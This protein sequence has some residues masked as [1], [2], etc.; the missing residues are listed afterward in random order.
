M[1]N[2]TFISNE[3]AKQFIR[4]K[5]K[6]YELNKIILDINYLVYTNN[7]EPLDYKTKSTLFTHIFDVVAGRKELQ[8]KEEEKNDLIPDFKDI[9]LLFERRNF[10][11]KQLKA[12]IKKQRQLS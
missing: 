3:M 12:G 8:L 6:N 1:S 9:T 5:D 11:L 10:I 4:A 2:I 7:H